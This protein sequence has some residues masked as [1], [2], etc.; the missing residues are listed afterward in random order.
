MDLME[1][2]R[3]RETDRDR[4]THTLIR[5]YAHPCKQ[6]NKGTHKVEMTMDNMTESWKG[7]HNEARDT[8]C[9][10]DK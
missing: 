5:T 1:R 2:E 9:L 6:T 4:H 3:E 10:H 7:L 8:H